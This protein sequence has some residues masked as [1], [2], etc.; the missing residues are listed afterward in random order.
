MSVYM[1]T[2]LCQKFHIPEIGL[3]FNNKN[4]ED[5]GTIDNCMLYTERF[6]KGPHLQLNNGQSESICGWEAVFKDMNDNQMVKMD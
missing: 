6:F 5:T 2:L 4:C 1:D 3:K